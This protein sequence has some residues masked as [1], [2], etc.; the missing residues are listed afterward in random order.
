[1]GDSVPS[2]SAL[3]R[4]EAKEFAAGPGLLVGDLTRGQDL[5]VGDQLAH[6]GARLARVA[7]QLALE[8]DAAPV[9]Q[10]AIAELEM[11]TLHLG[12]PI[13]E[14]I[15]LGECEQ[16]DARLW[17][18]VGDGEQ[19]RQQ[20]DVVAVHLV[21]HLGIGANDHEAES[22]LVLPERS[23]DLTAAQRRVAA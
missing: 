5:D 12:A 19:S 11:R 16:P 8:L 2:R 23:L 22:R 3:A 15:D 9:A 18:S 20:A 4:K 13:E 17:R 7:T 21:R 10:G 6:R 1:M 14:A